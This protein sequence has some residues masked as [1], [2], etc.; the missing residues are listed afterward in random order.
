MDEDQ[1]FSVRDRR[2]GAVDSSTEEPKQQADAADPKVR[3]AKAYEE[4]EVMGPSDLDFS[5]FVLSLATS[6][7]VGLGAVPHPETNKSAQNIPAAKQMIDIMAIL[8]EKTKG[9]LTESESALLEQVLFNLRIH[10]VRTVEGQ[11]K[12]GG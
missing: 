1:G 5:T 4:H 6:A 10:Y 11:K 2:A 12:S 8:Q 9:N 7:Q 3:A